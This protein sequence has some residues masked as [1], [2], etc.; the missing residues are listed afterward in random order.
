MPLNDED[1]QFSNSNRTEGC[2]WLDRRHSELMM[3]LG[4][5]EVIPG[6]MMEVS[7]AVLWQVKFIFYSLTGLSSNLG[8]STQAKSNV[9]KS[10][11]IY[12]ISHHLYFVIYEIVVE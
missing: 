8:T 4:A 6:V 12:R 1:S 9:L 3:M 10:S 7:K 2:E 5:E 11:C